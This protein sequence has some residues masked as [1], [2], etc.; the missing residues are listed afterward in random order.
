MIQFRERAASGAP[1]RLSLLTY[2]VL[3]AADILLH[4]THDVP[5]GADQSQ[6]VELTRDVAIRFNARYG[7]TFVVPRAVNPPFAARIMD[8]TDPA[9]KMGKSN[10]SQAGVIR[11]L[12]PPDAVARK[13]RRAVTD[14]D[15]EVRYDPATKPGVSNLLAILAA[16]TGTP[17]EGLRLRTYADLKAAV[18]DAVIDTLAPLQVRYAELAADPTRLRALLR[19]GADRARLRADATVVRTRGAMGLLAP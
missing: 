12:D 4:D 15:G 3:M 1:V 8:L 2:P 18:T 9:V 6:H 17:P 5:V 14:V 7:D 11:L 13:V 16:C 10:A 19:D